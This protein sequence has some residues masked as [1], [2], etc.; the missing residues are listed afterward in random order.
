M[1]I[2]EKRSVIQ[3]LAKPNGHMAN[4][5]VTTRQALGT[6]SDG[7]L[8]SQISAALTEASGIAAYRVDQTLTLQGNINIIY[9]QTEY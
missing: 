7:S 1:I 3:L 2:K 6:R 8:C 9:L 4:Q 5:S